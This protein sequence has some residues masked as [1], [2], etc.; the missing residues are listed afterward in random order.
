M[1]STETPQYRFVSRLSQTHDT[2]VAKLEA[3]G[4]VIEWTSSVRTKLIQPSEQLFTF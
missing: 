3:E 1:K 4:W 2:R